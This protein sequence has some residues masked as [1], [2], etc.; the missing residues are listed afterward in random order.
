MLPAAAVGQPD[1]QIASALQEVP[2]L[3]QRW[4]DLPRADQDVLGEF[5]GAVRSVAA[6]RQISVEEGKAFQGDRFNKAPL[7]EAAGEFDS[8]AAHAWLEPDQA[9]A[10]Q[11]SPSETSRDCRA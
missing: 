7:P 11:C 5:M 8:V 4:N 9:P 2:E 10:C 3:K 6:K 1:R